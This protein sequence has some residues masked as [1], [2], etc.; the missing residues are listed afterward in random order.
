VSSIQPPALP[1]ALVSLVATHGL[2]FTG[3]L[4]LCLLLGTLAVYLA[5]RED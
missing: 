4:V 3:G 5:V 2:L 1:P